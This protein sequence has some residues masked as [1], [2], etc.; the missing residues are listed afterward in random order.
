MLIREDKKK[1]SF[2]PIE[3]EMHSDN[4]YRRQT[5]FDDNV[6]MDNKYPLHFIVRRCLTC[7]CLDDFLPGT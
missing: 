4:N 1:V 2:S 3:M 6:A 7:I 5:I